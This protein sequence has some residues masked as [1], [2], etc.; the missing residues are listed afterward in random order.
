VFTA[1]GWT[2][3]N[4]KEKSGLSHRSSGLRLV[5][6]GFLR[7]APLLEFS[8]DV[9]VDRFVPKQFSSLTLLGFQLR[10]LGFE[11]VNELSGVRG[12]IGAAKK[13]H[14]V[15]SVRGKTKGVGRDVQSATARLKPF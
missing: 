12:V 2:R 11:L 14:G 3:K 5:N 8:L 13:G 4:A 1:E 10:V 9:A 6:I 15:K 7:Y